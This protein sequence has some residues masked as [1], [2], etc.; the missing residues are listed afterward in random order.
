MPILEVDMLMAFTNAADPLHAVADNLFKGIKNAKL[1]RVAVASS[2]YL[3][4]ELVHR[5]RGYSENEIS[6]DLKAFRRY[7]R[8]DEKPLTSRVLIEAAALRGKTE[9]TYFDSLHAATALLADK[10]IISVDNIYDRILE[11]KRRDPMELEL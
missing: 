2:A 11:L 6:E 8:L 10:I 7:P 9:I 1:G 3:E 4:Y 5:T